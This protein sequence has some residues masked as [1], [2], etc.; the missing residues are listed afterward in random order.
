MVPHSPLTIPRFLSCCAALATVGLLLS[1]CARTSPITHDI[2]A[3]AYAAH[4]PDDRVLEQAVQ[5]YLAAT[6][7]PAHSRYDFIRADLN[8]DNRRDALVMM[9]GPHHYWCDMNGCALIVMRAHDTGFSVLSEIAPVRGPFHIAEGTSAG[10]RDLIVRVSGLAH[11][12]AKTVVL[13]FDGVSYPE[14]PVMQPG[15]RIAALDRQRGQRVF[16]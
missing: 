3:A 12:P 6:G 2:P 13:R 11:A 16:P 5:D 1:G 8:G 15:D 7:R 9:K 4:D 10:W 14:N